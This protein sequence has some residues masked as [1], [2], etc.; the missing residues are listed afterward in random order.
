MASG[1]DA[2]IAQGPR[3]V[4]VDPNAIP[5]RIMTLRQSMQQQQMGQEQLQAAHQENQQR[6]IQMDQTRAI[7]QAYQ[8]ALKT[9]ADGNPTID[10][11][12]LTLALASNGHGSAIPAILKQ[13]DDLEKSH[14][15]LQEA[16]GK[17]AAQENEYAGS[18]GSAA[19]AANGDPQFF[20]TLATNAVRSKHVEPQI[21]Q[22]LIGQVTAAMQQDPTG[23][24]ARTLVGQIADHMIS[25]SPTQQLRQTQATTANARASTAKTESDKAQL[26]KDQQ[27]LQQVGGA[28]S[29]QQLDALRAGATQQG[30]SDAAIGRIPSMYSPDAMQA[31]SRTMMNADQ[32]AT[33][34]QTKATANETARHNQA[35]EAAA[36]TRNNI[37]G[38]ELALSKQKFD[39]TLGAGLDA[40]GQPLNPDALRAA[41]EKDP[42][43]VA[44][45]QYLAPD[46]NVR[47][48]LGQATMRKVYAMDKDHDATQFPARNKTA[49]DYSPAGQTGK[50][51]MSIDN[52]LAH[53]DML[54]RAGK[55]LDNNDLPDLNKI[56]LELGYRF[57]GSAKNVY[58]GIVQVVGPELIKGTLGEAG[59]EGER[60]AMGRT[61]TSAVNTKTREGTL[62]AI[63]EIFGKRIDRMREGYQQQMG[64]KQWNRQ[65]SADSQAVLQRYTQPSGGPPGGQK[66]A[67]LPPTLSQ[68]DVG[69]VYMSPNTGKPIKIKQVNPTDGT[70]FRSE[71]VQ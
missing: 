65:L 47:T 61:L 54:S 32:R 1:I 49:I 24:A 11:Q 56:A 27:Y 12:Q 6:Q 8:A 26:A 57:G 15:D 63:A 18:I 5:N 37:A 22:P 46:A 45:S 9:D 39:A 62:G 33:T 25:L 10:R 35:D 3:P 28:Q 43:A 20:L 60:G 64:G 7:N 55:A 68:G 19:K 29:Q 44:I 52:A 41:A 70:Q 31:F 48:A 69:K 67:P 38:G 36:K 30:I 2:L 14:V 71:P 23:A 13:V 34:D 4:Q 21:V 59:G 53:V 17:V 58:D 50:T 66:Y 42:V 51:F 40:N 16:K